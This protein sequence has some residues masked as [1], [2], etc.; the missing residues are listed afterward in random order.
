MASMAAAAAA[1]A[2][3]PTGTAAGAAAGT[4]EALQLAG[5]AFGQCCVCRQNPTLS[6]LA[7]AGRAESGHVSRTR[8]LTQTPLQ[9]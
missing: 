9:T 5:L 3:A 6:V 8:T 2:G 7:A 4:D 1:A